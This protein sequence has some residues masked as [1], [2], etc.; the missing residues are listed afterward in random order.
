MASSSAWRSRG[1]SVSDPRVLLLDEPLGALDKKLREHM[2]LEIKQLQ[3][4]LRV[5]VIYITH[6]Q[7]EA[8]TM[9]DRMR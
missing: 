7:E 1:P 5:T 4:K 6:D 2:Q 9:S 3:R 8:L